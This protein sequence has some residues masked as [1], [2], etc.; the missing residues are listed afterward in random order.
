MNSVNSLTGMLFTLEGLEI[1]A[2]NLSRE[3][4]KLSQSETDPVRRLELRAISAACKRVSRKPAETLQEAL[5]SIWIG[6]VGIHMENSN[7]GLSLGRLDQW[8]Q[9]FFERDLAQLNTEAEKE[10]YIKKAIETDRRLFYAMH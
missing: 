9:P 8:L 2:D 4:M 1:Y 10:Q 3:A 5:Q 6:W 7:T